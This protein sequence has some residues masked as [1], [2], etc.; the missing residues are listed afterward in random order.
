MQRLGIRGK[1]LLPVLAF[2]LLIGIG[3]IWYVQRLAGEQ[4]VQ[5]AL[6]E[7]KRLSSQLQE[8]REYYAKNVVAKVSEQKLEVT[9]DHAHKPAAIPLPAT[10]VHELNEA[11]NKKEG[12]TIRLYSRYPF[13]HRANGGPRDAFEEE[14]L[15]YLEKNPHSELW[16]REEY[17]GRAVVRYARADLMVSAACVNCHNSHPASPKTDWKLGDVRG[18]LELIVPI[19]HVLALAQAGM[20]NIA[21]AVGLALLGIVGIMGFLTHHLL[22]APLRQM[23]TASTRIAVGDLDQ[24]VE[25]RSSDEMGVLA[26]A[27]RSLV[28]YIKGIAGAA[29]ALSEKDLT[30]TVLPKSDRDLLS[31]NFERAF[32]SLKEMIRHIGESTATLSAASEELSATST[33]LGAN[34]EETSA[35]AH[36][37]SAA[38][39]EVSKN[40]QTVA[41]GT[42]EMSI[43]IKEIARNAQQA[44]GVACQAVQVAQATNAVVGKLGAGSVEIGKVIKV[45]TSIAEQTNLLALNATIEA[46]R[47][48][49]VGKGFSVVANEVKELA[50]ETAR[51]TEEIS[52]KI[53]A[54]QGGTRGALEAIE[55]IT[56]IIQQ[57]HDYQ[58]TIASAVEEQTA[59][60]NE[61]SRN[62]SEAA[63]ASVEIAQNIT[64]VA[65]A[66]ESTS[67]GASDSQKAAGEL[68]RMATELQR[69]V[70]QFHYARKEETA[71]RWCEDTGAQ[72]EAKEEH[73]SAGSWPRNGPGANGLSRAGAIGY[74]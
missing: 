10:M 21:I 49:E 64:G 47:A 40:I 19:D 63:K 68:A 4:A 62:L 71:P 65:Q 66:A 38:A 32:A 73:S 12:Y 23:T 67:G 25:F 36:V 69:L 54:I 13:P 56:S 39:E 16:R 14:A 41:T 22:F 17:Q 48:G 8:T 6:D 31:R 46:A 34:A 5:T 60:T 28:E 37:V 29:N 7:A 18:A 57:I 70:S 43:S 30:V 3:M 59:T 52:Q 58:S 9:H 35:Q 53:E 11:L 51:A 74:S 45:I 55:Q 33:Q 24:S 44:A 1:L 26:N 61:I 15:A 2:A 42:E 20:R 27:F 72:E 50:K